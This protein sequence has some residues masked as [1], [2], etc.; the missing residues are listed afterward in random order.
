M[1]YR[2]LAPREL[3]LAILQCPDLH[4]AGIDGWPTNDLLGLSRAVAEQLVIS[5]VVAW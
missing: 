2:H 1:R 4:S 5:R 3:D